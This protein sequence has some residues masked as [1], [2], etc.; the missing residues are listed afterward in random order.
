MTRYRRH[1]LHLKV[2]RLQAWFASWNRTQN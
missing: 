1:N 2:D